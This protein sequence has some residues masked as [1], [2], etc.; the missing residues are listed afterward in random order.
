MTG[1][2]EF[3]AEEW[4]TVVSAPLLAAMLVVAADKGG[5]IRESVAATHGYAA[6]RQRASVTTGSS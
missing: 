5:S 2:A 6:A 4:S 1:K 3:N